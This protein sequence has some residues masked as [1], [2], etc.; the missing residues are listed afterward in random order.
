M[1]AWNALD[2]ELA[3]EH[4]NVSRYTQRDTCMVFVLREIHIGISPTIEWYLRA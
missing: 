3:V 1:E 4:C 2:R